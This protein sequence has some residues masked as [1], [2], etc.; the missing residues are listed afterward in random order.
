M[1]HPYSRSAIACAAGPLIN[2]T[3]E[4]WQFAKFPEVMVRHHGGMAVSW[5]H[6][7]T[8]RGGGL[9]SL[10]RKLGLDLPSPEIPGR[11]TS[12]KPR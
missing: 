8:R 11:F 1:R 4:V 2:A 12:V 3:P 6:A 7:E 10:C 9:E 5:V